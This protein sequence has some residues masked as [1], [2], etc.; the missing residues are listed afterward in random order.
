MLEENVISISK[1][2]A[3]WRNK[4]YKDV[5]FT[6]VSN[7]V[8]SYVGYCVLEFLKVITSAISQLQQQQDNTRQLKD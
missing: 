1:I 7:V 5:T 8:Q 4:S 6:F 3:K 2:P